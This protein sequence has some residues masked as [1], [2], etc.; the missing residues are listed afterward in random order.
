VILGGRQGSTEIADL[1]SRPTGI[2]TD[3]SFLSGLAAPA[4]TAAALGLFATGCH[5]R[6]APA[7]THLAAANGAASGT[8]P[9]DNRNGACV[10]SGMKG[11]VASL[12][13]G[14][15]LLAPLPAGAGI[16]GTEGMVI[17]EVRAAQLS[18]VEAFLAAEQVAAQL[19]AWG[20]PPEQVAA[21]VAALSE[22][23]LERLAA[24]IETNPAGGDA[25]A[26][27]GAVFV[28]LIILELVGVTNIFRRI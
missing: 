24:T 28:V 2:G 23:E 5:A 12:A 16:V 27:I 15:L 9:A 4:I 7:I 26:L 1:V 20:V 17:Q 3:M 25:L 21:R 8:L 6:S 22:A 11:I 14:S 19:Q 18:K 13:I 10:M